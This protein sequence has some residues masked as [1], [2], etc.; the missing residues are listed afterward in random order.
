MTHVQ[1]HRGPDDC[2]LWEQRFPDGSYVALGNRRLAILDLS[3][4]GHMPMTNEDRSVVITYNGEVYNFADLR[5][6]LQ[7]KGYRFVSET[8]T[9]VV[10]HLYEEEG[11]DCVKR[12][13]GPSRFAICVLAFPR[14]S[15]L[16]TISE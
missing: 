14:Y 9:E 6:E 1:A 12:L 11:P 3:S 15:W 2:G 16:A 13:N 8:D 7:A 4:S 5:R 10:L